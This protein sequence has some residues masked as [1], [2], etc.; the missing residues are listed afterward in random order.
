MSVRSDLLK[1]LKTDDGFKRYVA[2]RKECETAFPIETIS[3]ELELILR[4]RQIRTLTAQS[5]L[6][7]KKLI[8]VSIDEA[9]KRARLTEII[10]TSRRCS[11]K[12][13][14][15]MDVMH[16]H[17]LSECTDLLSGVRTKGERD[18]IVQS[19][20]AKGW[21]LIHVMNATTERA[22]TII[23]DIDQSSYNLNRMVKLVEL[24]VQKEHIVNI[25]VH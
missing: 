24:I 12:L 15:V 16:Q 10:V 1:H 22:Q 5:K 23:E 18:Q 2:I 19:V 3:D 25:D 13:E 6:A 11:A 14:A 21:E 17:V 8:A 20:L 7:P 9:D 4:T